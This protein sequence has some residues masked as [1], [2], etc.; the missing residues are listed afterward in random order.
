MADGNS[1]VLNNR[2]GGEGFAQVD[3][4]TFEQIAALPTD[5]DALRTRLTHPVTPP[6]SGAPVDPNG[7]TA[8][9]TPSALDVELSL[10]ALLGEA[11]APA[12]VRAAAF[13]ALASRP[14][15]KNN[16]PS[17]VARSIVSRLGPSTFPAGNASASHSPER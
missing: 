1:T 16:G 3:R 10:V 11:P 4:L 17:P 14:N 7:N 13:R 15:I 6:G 12:D 8:P 5:P 9:P 2:D